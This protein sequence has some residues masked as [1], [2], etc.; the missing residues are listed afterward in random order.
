MEKKW[1]GFRDLVVGSFFSFGFEK[2]DEID[3]LSLYCTLICEQYLRRRKSLSHKK[4]N[5]TAVEETRLQSWT[6][7]L[8]FELRLCR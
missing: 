8:D 6:S 7:G 3:V 1:V 4:W 5:G 2:D